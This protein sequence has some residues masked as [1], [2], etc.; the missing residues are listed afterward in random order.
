[1]LIVKQTT[2]ILHVASCMFYKSDS[3]ID[4]VK[5]ARDTR[6]NCVQGKQKYFEMEFGRG[7]ISRFC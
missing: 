6:Q 2:N 5:N 1:L 7:K 3:V 4:A